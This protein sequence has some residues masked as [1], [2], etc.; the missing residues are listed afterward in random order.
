[1]ACENHFDASFCSFR[2]IRPLLQVL[3]SVP[4][5]DDAKPAKLVLTLLKI[6]HNR[7]TDCRSR[8]DIS[9]LRSRTAFVV[10]IATQT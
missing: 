7:M 9:F 8:Y 1:M 10:Y 2:Y 4:V 5:S 6:L 3:R